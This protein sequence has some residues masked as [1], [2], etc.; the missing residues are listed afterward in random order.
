MGKYAAGAYPKGTGDD[1]DIARGRCGKRMPQERFFGAL[2]KKTLT[3]AEAGQR[4]CGMTALKRRAYGDDSTG[5][6]RRTVLEQAQDYQPAETMTDEVDDRFFEPDYETRQ[7][8]CI[9]SNGTVDASI[10]KAVGREATV[11]EMSFEVAQL[12]SVHPQA[13]DQDHRF[14]GRSRG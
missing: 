4:T 3:D 14:A 1:A 10:A 9:L 5:P 6:R 13:M 2:A 7:L 12:H 8:L 11:S